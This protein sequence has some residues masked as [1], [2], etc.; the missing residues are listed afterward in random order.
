MNDPYT[1]RSSWWEMSLDVSG[2]RR[3]IERLHGARLAMMDRDDQEETN[4]RIDLEMATTTET[5]D[6]RLVAMLSDVGYYRV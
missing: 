5:L 4:H 1:Y 6:I 3:Q 2:G